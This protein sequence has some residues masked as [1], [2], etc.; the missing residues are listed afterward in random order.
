MTSAGENP[1]V[2]PTPEGV[3]FAIHVSP[4]ARRDRVGGQH[5]DALRVAVAAPPVEGRAHAALQADL[6][7]ALGVRR[8]DVTRVAGARGRHKR[9][10]V[11]G[12]PRELERQVL[13]LR[14][15]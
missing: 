4:R 5:G 10:A 1:K 8:T 14:D 7:A 12:D 6:A 3:T 9:V 11:R 2:S 15:A 13:A